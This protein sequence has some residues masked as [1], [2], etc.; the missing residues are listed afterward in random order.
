VLETVP[1]RDPEDATSNDNIGWSFFVVVILIDLVA[2]VLIPVTC[3]H[4][5]NSSLRSGGV[6]DIETQVYLAVDERVVIVEPILD[7]Y[8]L[9][10]KEN[11][12]SRVSKPRRN[13]TV[14]VSKRPIVVWEIDDDFAGHRNFIIRLEDELVVVGL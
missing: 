14:C 4:K 8:L 1:E 5:W 7:D 13:G 10:D 2:A 3:P 11:V 6:D 12:A 9:L